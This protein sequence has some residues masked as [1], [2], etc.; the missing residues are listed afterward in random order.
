MHWNMILE[1]SHELELQRADGAA[2]LV[3]R[4]GVHLHVSS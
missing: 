4:G 2:V 1:T 3:V